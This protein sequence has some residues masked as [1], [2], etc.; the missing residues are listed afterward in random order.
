MRSGPSVSWPSSSAARPE[1]SCPMRSSGGA[2]A[3][4]ASARIRCSGE[5]RRMNVEH[6]LASKG[7]EVKTIRPNVSIAEALRRLRAEGIGSLVVSENGT[8]LAGILSDRDILD[9][10]ADHGIDILGESVRGVMTEEV[11]TCSREDW[12]SRIMALMTDRRI[13]HVPVVEGDG[14]LCGMISIGDV[15]KQRLDE[16]EGEADA[17]R[18]Y[19][20]SAM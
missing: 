15:V 8:N 3:T 14:R 13:R 10:I 5:D 12:V 16:I 19:V 2:C 7:R 6:I 18:E 11:F 17:L 9:A 1:R 20:T 4:R